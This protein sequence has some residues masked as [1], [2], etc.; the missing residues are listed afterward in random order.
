LIDLSLSS[1]CS[2]SYSMIDLARSSFIS[3]IA[4]AASSDSFTAL[5]DHPPLVPNT[6][7]MLGTSVISDS[8]FQAIVSDAFLSISI[9]LFT[10]LR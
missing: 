3:F 1:L 6:S 2:F 5:E 10:S 8:K 4:F 9:L 7:G